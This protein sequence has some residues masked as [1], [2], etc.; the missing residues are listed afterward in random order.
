MADASTEVRAGAEAAGRPR[1]LR[2]AVARPPLVQRH[3]GEIVGRRVQVWWHG[4]LRWFA[5]VVSASDRF[6]RIPSP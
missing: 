5:G 3:R 4:D 2:V 6:T 1:R